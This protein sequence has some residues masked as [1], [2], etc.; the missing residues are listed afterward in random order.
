MTVSEKM[1][2]IS[3][4]HLTILPKCCLVFKTSRLCGV[5]QFWWSMSL[6]LE[7]L[8]DVNMDKP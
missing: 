1:K 8:R 5:V 2:Y 4:P 3:E 7:L 6:F